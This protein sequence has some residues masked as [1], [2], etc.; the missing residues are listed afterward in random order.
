M[1]YDDFDFFVDYTVC[2]SCGT[3]GP[4]LLVT[5]LSALH[6]H[7]LVYLLPEVFILYLCLILLFP[8]YF[9]W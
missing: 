1:L 5:L 4:S 7:I 6:Y 9:I 3:R 2:F 8:L